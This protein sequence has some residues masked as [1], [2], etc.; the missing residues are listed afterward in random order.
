MA[1]HDKRSWRS[2][3]EHPPKKI[4]QQNKNIGAKHNNT[5]GEAQY[6]IARPTTTK[7]SCN[8]PNTQLGKR[9]SR[10]PHFFQCAPPPKHTTWQTTPTFFS[11]CAPLQNTQLGKTT[12]YNIARPTHFSMCAPLQENKTWPTTQQT[13]LQRH[14]ISG[15]RSPN[16]THSQSKFYIFF[17]PSLKKVGWPSLKKVGPAR[18][19][20]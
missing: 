3:I 15:I 12:Q 20:H 1:K 16:F 19:M 7:Q 18:C 8:G 11:M 14:T 5:T 4:L 10:G 2:T 6:N 13:Q 9:Q 17:W